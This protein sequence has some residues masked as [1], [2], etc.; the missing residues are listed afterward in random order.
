VVHECDGA[1]NKTRSVIAATNTTRCTRS[2]GSSATAWNITSAMR[3]KLTTCL[4]AGDPI[5][6]VNITWQC[7]QQLR[8]IYHALAVRAGVDECRR[9]RAMRRRVPRQESG[10]HKPSQRLSASGVGHPGRHDR[11]GDPKL[12]EGCYFPDWL[13][14]RRTTR[15]ARPLSSMP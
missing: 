13:L 4:D 10:P 8:S 14:E 3:A 11:V 12:R 6:E 9:R 15:Q 7:H 5:D 1:C 2:E